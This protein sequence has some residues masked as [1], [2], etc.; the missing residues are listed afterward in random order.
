MVLPSR[1]SVRIWRTLPSW[2]NSMTLV[3]TLPIVTSNSSVRP[4]LLI[5]LASRRWPVPL[6][7]Q[8]HYL[9]RA[10]AGEISKG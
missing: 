4:F 3:T 10:Q 6:A 8:P 9:R 5:S 1:F 2:I 7:E